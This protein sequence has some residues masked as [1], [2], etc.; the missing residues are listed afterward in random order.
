[1]GKYNTANVARIVSLAHT[2]PSVQLGRIV[3]SW[4][5]ED[6]SLLVSLVNP[7]PSLLLNLFENELVKISN[8]FTFLAADRTSSETGVE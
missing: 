8:F 6:L 4:Q 3:K 2:Y 7:T 1:M 5:S